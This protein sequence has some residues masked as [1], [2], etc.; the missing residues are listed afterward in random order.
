MREL[1]RRKEH[2]SIALLLASDLRMYCYAIGYLS[3]ARN[4]AI[5]QWNNPLLSNT[6]QPS[7]PYFRIVFFHCAA[8]F[9]SGFAFLSILHASR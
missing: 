6:Q 3:L 2:C 1:M 9:R 5:E 8:I 4:E 7:S